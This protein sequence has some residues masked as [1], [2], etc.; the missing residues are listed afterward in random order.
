MPALSPAFGA[1]VFDGQN[2]TI[3]TT[4]S[5]TTQVK[6]GAGKLAKVIVDV[7]FS[8]IVIYDD[9]GAGTSNQVHSRVATG[10]YELM[11]PIDNGIKVVVGT[12]SGRVIIVWT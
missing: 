4:A 6:T 11:L 12:G 7:T 1:E 5:S 9:T 2:K 3:I 8:T 10:E